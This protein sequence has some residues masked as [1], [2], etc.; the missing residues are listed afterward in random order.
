MPLKMVHANL[1]EMR[2]DAIVNAANTSLAQG[3]G[4]CGA[5]FEAAGATAMQEA[6]A[7]IGGCATGEAV[8]TPGFRLPAKYV[9]HTPGPVWAGGAHGEAELLAACYRNALTLAQQTGL[10]SIAFPLI[11]AGIYGYPAE[12][13]L[14]VAV[15]TIGDYLL[16]HDEIEVYLVQFGQA[17]NPPDTSM[18]QAI[19]K[20]L[21]QRTD[22]PQ[23]P[24][25]T[26]PPQNEVEQ[27][28]EDEHEDEA[29]RTILD[30]LIRNTRNRRNAAMD[31]STSVESV[32]EKAA[33]SETSAAS[34]PEADAPLAPHP[35]LDGSS[36]DSPGMSKNTANAEIPQP[37][38]TAKS[39]RSQPKEPPIFA[40]SAVRR[41]TLQ[42]PTGG[43][44]V[45]SIL[46]P[47]ARKYQ[48]EAE[49]QASLPRK[50]KPPKAAR[51]QP[52]S[53]AAHRKPKKKR[54]GSRARGWRWLARLFHPHAEEENQ[55][56]AEGVSDDQDDH[57]NERIKRSKTEEFRQYSLDVL[58]HEEM[59][60]DADR[61]CAEN[62]PGIASETEK[63]P[64][65][66]P[67]R[68]MSLLERLDAFVPKQSSNFE[69]G[70]S[71][72]PAGRRPYDARETR[73]APDARPRP[74]QAPN[75]RLGDANDPIKR[76]APADEPSENPDWLKFPPPDDF[77]FWERFI[78]QGG[79]DNAAPT[80]D[81][82]NSFAPTS[83]PTGKS[84]FSTPSALPEGDTHFGPKGWQTAEPMLTRREEEAR[85]NEARKIADDLSTARHV[86]ADAMRRNIQ[87]LTLEGVLLEKQDTFSE[88]VLGR[89]DQMHLKDP[90]VY[91]RANLD[92]KLF[93][94]LRNGRAY[95]PSRRTA[96][97]LCVALE[98]TLAEAYDLLSRAG[99]TLSVASD[100]DLI[101]AYFIEHE[102]YDIFDLNEALF[103][104]NQHC[105]G[106]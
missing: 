90:V 39:D 43:R 8:L 82:T 74:F 104:F 30:Y 23:A 91:K 88:A 106:V 21:S 5:I 76:F 92:R 59:F 95:S 6:C 96:L 28:N 16:T 2:T 40:S 41:P 25:P 42:P 77:D 61:T 65:P 45:L 29:L 53:E 68:K 4:V 94:K 84:E 51:K 9:I 73:S 52:Q 38:S 12:Q 18:S 72:Y 14:H 26:A 33:P 78:R 55:H 10:Q 54:E 47:L 19:W 103:T 66:P 105:L 87:R 35:P 13:A 98:L 3:G 57:L 80:D 75:R 7:A 100:A 11:S 89:I 48:L 79:A 99:Y 46:E 22:A 50:E 17:P 86:G 34:A 71:A 64:S 32:A 63:E 83:A 15:R 67:V 1:V 97:S 85:R 49:E 31:D 44:P 70:E 81:A 93:S 24:V 101:I 58:L 27:E 102:W 60:A 56:K 36:S 20:Y 37:Q 62:H 69:E